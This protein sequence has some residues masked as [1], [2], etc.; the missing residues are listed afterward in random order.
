MTGRSTTGADW[1][2]ANL[3]DAKGDLKAEIART[4]TKAGLLLAFTGTVLAGVLAA[5]ATIDVVLPALVVAG[6]AC[7]VLAGAAMVLLTAVRPHLGGD[8]RASF[9]YWAR[10]T[11]EQIT[12]AMRDDRR[13]DVVRVLSGIAVRKYC[14]LQ[15]A[16]DLIRLAVVLLA[17]A[18]L[19]AA[20]G[21]V[22]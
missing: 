4:D 13:A 12:A 7:G 3:A 17:L 11:T 19:V 2:H 16:V 22:W 6:V 21:V 8:D 14:A 20:A 18:V 5:A 10:L 1:T 9:P 15:R